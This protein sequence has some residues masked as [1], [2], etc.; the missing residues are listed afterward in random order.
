MAGATVYTW[1]PIVQ[2][3]EWASVDQGFVNA[4]P[5][6]A[7]VWPFAYVGLDFA[8]NEVAFTYGSFIVEDGPVVD[9][10]ADSYGHRDTYRTIEGNVQ[11]KVGTVRW[12]LVG[13]LPPDMTFDGLS[14]VLRGRIDTFD[15]EIPFRL[16]AIDAD[17][18]TGLSNRFVVATWPADIS[19]DALSRLEMV[20]GRPYSRRVIATDVDGEQ[21]WSVVE[22]T[23]PPGLSFD[24][25][26]RFHGT[27]AMIGFS[28]RMVAQHLQTASPRSGKIVDRP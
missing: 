2:F 14:G 17:G 10:I 1:T 8:G 23:L 5:T 28:K 19:I 13:D 6:E 11:R 4:V 7:G 3:P 18:T 22:G 27:P 25:T 24:A 9:F 26:G 21:S 12:E 20:Q 15:T 16:K